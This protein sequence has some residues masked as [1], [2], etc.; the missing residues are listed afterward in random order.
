MTLE[1]R[2]DKCHSR[3]SV[4]KLQGRRIYMCARCRKIVRE[5]D[6]K[7]DFL[8]DPRLALFTRAAKAHHVVVEPVYLYQAGSIVGCNKKEVLANKLICQLRFANKL[9]PIGKGFYWYFSIDVERLAERDVVT[10]ACYDQD[11]WR[12]HNISADLLIAC[13]PNKAW[14]DLR[15][16]PG[17]RSTGCGREPIFDCCPYEDDWSVFKESHHEKT[18]PAVPVNPVSSS[19]A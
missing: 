15:I 1:T 12:F 18:A 17:G 4:R 3:R 6:A 8:N 9:Q 2:C 5:Q 7:L 14:I 16:P 13:H 10:L 11:E 19:P